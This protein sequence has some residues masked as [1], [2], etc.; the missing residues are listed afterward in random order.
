[1]L[2]VI[3]ELREQAKRQKRKI[4]LPE[5]EDK[6]VLEAAAYI[7]TEGLADIILVGNKEKIAAI[8]KDKG[9]NLDG[10]EIA[11]LESS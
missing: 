3:S 10:I 9:F 8:S 2:K 6:R 4:V 11:D 5:G 1:M 7:K